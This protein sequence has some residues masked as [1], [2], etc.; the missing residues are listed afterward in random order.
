MADLKQ[1]AND[2]VVLPTLRDRLRLRVKESDKSK[3]GIIKQ[4]FK[5]MI[6]VTCVFLYHGV[7]YDV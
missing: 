5:I 6:T 3:L 1:L 2:T 4:Y 7:L